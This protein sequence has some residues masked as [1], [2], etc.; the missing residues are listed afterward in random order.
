MSDLLRDDV[1]E[2]AIVG[3]T[4]LWGSHAISE[5][6][7]RG[8]DVAFFGLGVVVH[9]VGRGHGNGLNGD[10]FAL[11]DMARG[12]DDVFHQSVSGCLVDDV[13]KVRERYFLPQFALAHDVGRGFA[14]V[15][16][17]SAADNGLWHDRVRVNETWLLARVFDDVVHDVGVGRDDVFFGCLN[18]ADD[19]AR[20]GDVVFSGCLKYEKVHDSAKGAASAFYA[21]ENWQ[22]AVSQAR[23]RDDVFGK[24][25]QAAWWHDRV[26]VLDWALS[27]DEQQGAMI[28]TANVDT[29]A[30]SQYVANPVVQMAVIDGVVYGFGRNGVFVLGDEHDELI[31]GSL[32]MGLIDTS[33]GGLLHPVGSYV[34]YERD[35][36]AV[37][38]LAVSMSQSGRDERFV[39]RLARERASSLTN[40][41]F[42]FGRGL[43]GRHFGFELMIKGKW[44]F[45]NDWTVDLTPTKRRI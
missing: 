15:I 12:R 21:V 14:S 45:L 11:V 13:A 18:V 17:G 16:D 35:N 6:G 4:W 34:E 1:Q 36:G 20:M 31:S 42:V 7:G 9:D 22:V 28:W 26:A 41:R 3:E 44:A 24:A 19:T 38:D 33:G 32:K 27:D 25:E 40:G 2:T 39:Y 5:D 30:V 23:V 43:R 8:R 29:W 37:V 10:L